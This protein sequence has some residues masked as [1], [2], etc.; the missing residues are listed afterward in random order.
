MNAGENPL[1][2]A[3]GFL[4]GRYARLNRD[5]HPDDEMLIQYRNL[6]NQDVDAALVAYF[7][8]GSRLWTAMAALL[9]W[10]FPDGPGPSFQ[11]LDFAS[12]FGRVT[13]FIVLD[14]PP[15]RIWVADI[16]A[17]G[18][19]FQEE[20]L[21]VHGL[22]SHADPERFQCGEAFDMVFVSSLFTH[23][24]EE[25]FRSWLRRL[26][27]LVR[28]GGLLAFSVHDRDI[29]P[30]GE[31]LPA[32]GM[33][34]HPHSESGS[35]P[36][37]QYGTTWVDEPFV[38]RLAGEVAQGASVHRIPR[39]LVNFQDL[40][41]VV[42]EADCD[43]SGLR[44][45]AMPEVFVEHASAVG[46]QLRLS[47]WVV[48][49]VLR[50]QPRELRVRIN[51]ELRASHHDFPVR[52]EV[53]ALFPYE[54]V[55]GYGWRLL[56]PLT[57]G[58]LEKNASLEIEVVDADGSRAIPESGPLHDALLRSVRMDLYMTRLEMQRLGA[59]AAEEKARSER[60]R[61]EVQ[62]LETRLA[63]MRASRFWKLRNAWFRVKR[64]IGLTREE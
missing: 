60:L 13:R 19:R 45:R 33:L 7:D 2:A 24:P 39:G 34:F 25:T 10:R 37:E 21:G 20:Q 9:H 1:L 40:Y 15:E 59:E 52:E 38:R 27:S 28:P 32:S 42:P 62:A 51:G 6:R 55:T 54:Q 47:G 36:S 44:W 16:Y 17:E 50:R 58:D 14:L 35:L 29:L 23:L 30:P 12:G 53:G 11:L 46:D 63:G 18:V 56:S 61:Q 31:G 22:V 26:W 4:S 43:F 64:A 49:R 57:P 41:V 48:D 3:F 8:S 5:I